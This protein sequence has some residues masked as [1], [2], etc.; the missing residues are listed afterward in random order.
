MRAGRACV[1]VRPLNDDLKYKLYVT[2]Y[3]LTG[4]TQT[5][6]EWRARR[7]LNRAER[8]Q[9]A[10]ET[11]A[12]RVADVRYKCVCGNLLLASDRVC[13]A[14][15]RRQYM[16]HWARKIG[17]SVGQALPEAPANLLIGVIILLGYTIELRY[18][19][20]T[21]FTPTKGPRDIIMLGASWAPLTL[22]GNPWRAVTY[23]FLHGGLMH[24]LF[25]GMVLLYIGPMIERTFGSARYLALFL[26]TGAGAGY[27]A[28]LLDPM[29]FVIGASGSGFGLMGVAA[30]WGHRSRTSE[31][32]LIR[33]VMVRWMVYSTLFGLFVG[34]VAHDIHFLGL[35]F[36]L[37]LTPLLQP[38][39]QNPTRQRIT[40]VIG[41]VSLTFLAWALVSFVL[42]FMQNQPQLG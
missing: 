14:C 25:N 32:R 31:G 29:N 36:G 4:S 27:V 16:P 12:E 42:W 28:C 5:Q 30:L 19:G 41:A 18:G 17:R 11:R 34:G 33:D 20:G 37:L 21:F 9:Q 39:G 10:A 7:A 1:N 38:A 23:M 13:D 26:F 3:R 40:P 35:G 2:W 15:G 8:E 24:L 22:H 6:A